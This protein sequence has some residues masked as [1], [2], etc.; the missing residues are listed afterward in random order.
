MPHIFQFRNL[1][2]FSW[3]KHGVSTVEIGNTNGADSQDGRK[4][5]FSAV[6]LSEENIV[7]LDQINGN[8][9]YVAT[10]KDRGKFILERDSVITKDSAVALLVKSADCVPI[11]LIDKHKRIIAA[12]HAG[13]RGTAQEIVRLTIEHMQDHFNTNPADIIAG[14]GPSIGPCC[15]EVDTLVIEAFQYQFPKFAD[16]WFSKTKGSH[17]HFDLWESN[18]FQLI[19]K[20]VKKENIEVARICTYE[21]SD[22]TGRLGSVLMINENLPS[23]N[24]G[25]R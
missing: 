15:Y 5:F 22:Y 2:C 8:H 3:L 10:K 6:G 11:L 4:K 14:I 21:H 20:G 16:K 17:T 18:K 19:E 1:S 9:V 7:E 24:Y 25:I 12:V 23:K 13:W